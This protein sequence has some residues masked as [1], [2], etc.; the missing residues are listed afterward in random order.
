MDIAEIH[1]PTENLGEKAR[2]RPGVNSGLPWSELQAAAILPQPRRT[3]STGTANGTDIAGA[4]P[5]AS[6]TCLWTF[7]KGRRQHRGCNY[8][9]K[10]VGSG[11]MEGVVQ[12]EAGCA[13]KA[14]AH[15]SLDGDPNECDLTCGAL[16]ARRHAIAVSIVQRGPWAI[17]SLGPA[18]ISDRQ[19]H[20]SKHEIQV[21]MPERAQ[22]ARRADKTQAQ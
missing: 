1:L 8:I 18:A 4:A 13:V 21:P 15:E 19:G 9:H 3:L 12:A 14:P 22:A 6:T 17:S 11:G 5:R 10:P 20:R 7:G 2:H 16:G